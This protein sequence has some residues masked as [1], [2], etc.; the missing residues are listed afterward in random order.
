MFR[1]K[2]VVRPAVATVLEATA[3]SSTQVPA[4]IQANSSPRVA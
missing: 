1:N 2:E 3:Y 4:M